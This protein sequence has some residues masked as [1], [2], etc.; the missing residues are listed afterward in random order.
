MP[1]AQ[2][3]I[4]VTDLSDSYSAV[5]TNE[6]TVIYTDA[7]GNGGDYSAASTVMSILIG[8]FD[9]SAT[10]TVTAAASTGV[11][12]TLT[13][14]TYKVN[15][16]SVNNGYVDL[17]ATKSGQVTL[18]KRFSISKARQG[19]TGAAGATGATGPQGATGAKGDTG[20]TG[21][22]GPTGLQ[23][24]QGPKGDQGIAGP[25]GANGQTS[26][27]HIAYAT[28]ATGTAGFSVSDSNGKTYIGMY[29]DFTATD[30][31]DPAK[32]KWT[33]IKGADGAQGIQ[34]PTGPSG[35]TPYFHTAYATNSTGTAGFSTTVT[36]G[37]TYIGTYTD[38]TAADSTDP[39]KYK[40]VLIQGPTGATGATGPQG[41]A[42][43]TGPT[44]ATGATGPQ[45]SQGIQGPIGPSGQPTY[46]W[47]KYAD[48]PTSGMSDSPTGKTYMGVAYNKSTATESTSYADYNWS[49]IQGP[50]GNQGIQGP[51]GP[52]GQATYT[53]IKYADDS[54]G[55]GLSD[56]PTGKKYIGMAHNKTTATEST[57][58]VD[59]VWSLILG[60]QGPTG[61]TGATG[62]QGPT[63]NTGPQGV[64]G[65]VGPN[66]AATYTW[67]KYGASSAGAGMSDDPAGKTYIGIAYNKTTP[68]ESTTAT[69][70]TW[71]LIKGDQ[72]IAGPTGPQ[73]ATG[74]TGATGPQ[75]PAGP[76]LYTWI[77][78]ADSPTAGMSD[79]PTG[80]LY[81]GIA[82]NKT[83]ATKSTAYADY[84][85]SLIKNVDPDT[86]SSIMVN[87]NF[88]DW[89]AGASTPTGWSPAGTTPNK[90]AS[91]NKS[92]GNAVEFVVAAGGTGYLQQT[93]YNSVAY[94]KY[95]YAEVTFKLDAGMLAGSGLLVRWSATTLKD[96]II[97]FADMIPS[98]VIG[99][100][101]TL[102]KVFTFEDSPPAGF[103]GYQAYPMAGW[104]G[105]GKTVAAKTIEFDSVIVRP[106]T[107]GEVY[108][109]Q[110]GSVV[111]SWKSKAANSKNEVRINGGLIEAN[112]IVAQQ[113]AVGDFTNLSQV[114]ENNNP[115]GQTVVTLN[116]KKYFSTGPAASAKLMM[117]TA[118]SK[119]F[120]KD[121]QYYVTV[122][123]YKDSGVATVKFYVR[124]QYTDGT[125]ANAGSLMQNYTA[126]D[127]KIEGVVTITTD[128]DPLKTIKR[129]EF[130]SE[131]DGG[132]TGN[133]YTRDIDIRKMGTGKLIVDGSITAQQLNVTTLSAISAKLGNVSIG[134]GGSLTADDYSGSDGIAGTMKV[135]S[136]GMIFNA[137]RAG[138]DPELYKTQTFKTSYDMKKVYFLDE[139]K[140]TYD[141]AFDKRIETTLQ[142]GLVE[143]KI[144]TE[145]GVKRLSLGMTESGGS[146][147]AANFGLDLDADVNFMNHSLFGVN[148]IQINDPGAS[149]GIEWMGGNGW[150]IVETTDA[151]GNAA[152]NLQITQGNTTG[153][154]RFTLNTDGELILR[155]PGGT[156]RG[157][158]NGQM[159][160]VGSDPA[161]V[162][163]YIRPEGELRVTA[164][165]STST[166][167][168]IRA[169]NFYSDGNTVL[170]A[171][172]GY[173]VIRTTKADS[174]VYLQSDYE[175]RSVAVNTT[176]TYK[177]VRASSF[178][179]GSSINYKQNLEKIEE[180]EVDPLRLI[181][182]TQVWKYHLNSNV[183]SGVYDKP[184]VGLI[185]EMVN[186]I[187][188]DEDGVDPYTIASVAW[189]GI[190]QL[191]DMVEAQAAEIET[192]K[193]MHQI[194]QDEIEELKMMV[195]A[196]L[197][198]I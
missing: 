161:Y 126:T 172:G 183:D 15:S 88:A 196:L 102:S 75:G 47:L 37:K 68:T 124:Y 181:L 175:T 107:A 113:I 123:G 23:G 52:Q 117:A 176:S 85:W 165:N 67:I 25:T 135:N 1:L 149:E 59:Y 184:K 179:T 192:L 103:N 41:I 186:P 89:P 129:V 120:R 109:S 150:R 157:R 69:D 125:W 132:T 156:E 42:G 139:Q 44:G 145:E 100:W 167:R 93:R 152:G 90:V 122:N 174:A 11:T 48:S 166:L 128:A 36:T 138:A 8:G 173:V 34:G 136:L 45:G 189:G 61:A 84:S 171:D 127:T 60:P 70:Y 162:N 142:A 51:T 22:Q 119:E 3:Q 2:G 21:P 49:L 6:A 97:D 83:T 155:N 115:D 63:G 58:A 26:Y 56:S 178:P 29:T 151:M 53:W 62:P 95:L 99:Q 195:Q 9:D 13:G 33:L 146:I 190:Q 191:N 71:S 168:N 158:L 27:T 133:Y 86:A 111:D 76:Q 177:P 20:A 46:I 30:S 17:Q 39:A 31:A 38:F 81:M 134:A 64:Q 54:A 147:L 187:I 55:A 130:F 198:A 106:A 18:N 5:L 144:N 7:S 131:K 66:G 79:S 114:N 180:T 43:P 154:R 153:S 92:N 141:A 98:P 78:Y 169:A 160:D 74:S 110:T 35:Q 87:S 163:L 73:G 148:H 40:W 197:P 159:W 108:S 80:K 19:S 96:Q 91:T 121:D 101:Y 16:M 182:D 104:T 116:G 72:G 57:N 164:P 170:M 10:W 94:S 32:Y 28:N 24:I 143:M 137:T 14:K 105:F 4:T 50:Q 12:G 194:Q 77:K 65:P 118:L 185:S 82:Y 193:E 188:R 112:T 140:N